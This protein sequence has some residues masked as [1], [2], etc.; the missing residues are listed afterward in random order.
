MSC[1]T[2][3]MYK[4]E[5]LQ[6]LEL[7]EIRFE[8]QKFAQFIRQM[9]AAYKNQAH[10]KFSFLPNWLRPRLKSV[11]EL[12]KKL[13]E[14]KYRDSDYS[15][16]YYANIFSYNYEQ[17]ICRDLKKIC[18]YSVDEKISIPIKAIS[19]FEYTKRYLEC[20]EQNA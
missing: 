4:S 12:G 3:C 2:I 19:T 11:K 17:D 10:F 16:P 15:N 14:K 1:S 8:K 20:L 5:V 6:L 7:T 18:K 9:K 13:K